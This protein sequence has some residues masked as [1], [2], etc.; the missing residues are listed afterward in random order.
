[1]SHDYIGTVGLLLILAGWVW[2]FWQALKSNKPGVP[3]SFALLYGA[4]SL[5][6]TWHSVELGDIVFIVLNAAATLIAAANAVFALTRGKK[7]K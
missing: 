1:M 3:L 2:E 5:L 4:G 6:L 7:K